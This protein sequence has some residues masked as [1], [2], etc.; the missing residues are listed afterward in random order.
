MRSESVKAVA[1][2]LK[3]DTTRWDGDEL[4]ALPDFAVVLGLVP[5]L[6]R[7]SIVEKQR[8]VQII[9]AKAG[10]DEAKYLKLMQTH[11]RLRKEM[12]RLGS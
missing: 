5:D 8:L 1:R 11:V 10:K 9:Q 7:W 12:I 4:T 3:T 6:G 2:V